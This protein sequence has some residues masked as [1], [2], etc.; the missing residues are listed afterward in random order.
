MSHYCES[1]IEGLKYQYLFYCTERCMSH[2][3]NPV[4]G[5]KHCF[6][7]FYTE[8]AFGINPLAFLFRKFRGNFF[9]TPLGTENS[10]AIKSCVK[11]TLEN[12][13]QLDVISRIMLL[14]SRNAN[15][16]YSHYHDHVILMLPLLHL[17]FCL[18]GKTINKSHKRL[19]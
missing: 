14:L 16:T 18:A 2:R 6:M 1:S 19:K 11:S 5:L 12:F 9:D 13:L 17:W 3:S 10:R 15:C 4:R 7:N 8:K